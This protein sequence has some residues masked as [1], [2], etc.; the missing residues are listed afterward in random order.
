[1]AKLPNPPSDLARIPPGIRRLPA[2][3]ELWR[4]YKRAGRH[5]V[6]WNTFRAYGPLKT[7]RF[8]HHL[9]DETGAPHSQGRM[10]LY[11]AAEI[12]T[13]LAEFFQD[14][15]TID[16]KAE[17]VCLA[18]FQLRLDVELLDLTQEWP[19]Q[20]GASM[21]INSGPRSRS[22]LWSRAAYEAYPEIQG[23]YYASSMHANRPSIAF[24]ERAGPALALT[25]IFNRPLSEPA[26]LGDLD[27]AAQSLGYR[28][29]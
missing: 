18:G 2:G 3:T 19:T 13:C 9:P 25:P 6:L 7:A 21:A 11:A 10:I 12:T 14:T 20:A 28:L 24:Y 17:E 5:P 27:R 1:L 8:D 29:I 22:R 26:L 15:R 16:R 23:F 4:I